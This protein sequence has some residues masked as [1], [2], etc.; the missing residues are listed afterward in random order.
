VPHQLGHGDE[1]LAVVELEAPVQV[2]QGVEGA[3]MTIPLTMEQDPD[4]VFA[5][6]SYW[7]E[8]WPAIGV[9]VTLLNRVIVFEPAG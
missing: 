1:R 3:T 6:A 2:P 9:K 8:Q 5:L 4:E 7:C